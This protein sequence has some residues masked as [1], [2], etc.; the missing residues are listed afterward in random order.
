LL[1]VIVVVLGW[2]FRLQLLTLAGT[3]LVEDDGAVKADAIVVLGG[4]GYGTRI[5]RGAELKQRGYASRVLVC[6]PQSLL[7]HE[8]DITIAYAGKKG[9]PAALFEAIDLPE[10]AKST[11]TEAQYVGGLLRAQ[12]VKSIDLVTSNFHTRRAAWLWR[13]E[14]PGISIHVVPAPDPNFSPGTWFK[15]R[16][17]EKTFLLEWTKTIFSHAGD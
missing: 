15:T 1:F 13:K 16:E 17:G 10:S 8:S 11:R 2:L 7:G 3:A 12:G 5:L 4:D 6:G 9:Y 14:V